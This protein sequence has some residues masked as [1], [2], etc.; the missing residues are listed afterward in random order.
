MAGHKHSQEGIGPY[1]RCTSA[2]QGYTCSG[3]GAMNVAKADEEVR[4][5]ITACLLAMERADPILDAMTER[6][7]ALA[8]PFDLGVLLGHYQS[9]EAWNST[10]LPHR[11]E[12]LALTI[13]KVIIAP[14]H[15]RRIP[16]ADRVRV[17]LLGEGASTVDAIRC[18]RFRTDD[19]GRDTGGVST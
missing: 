17:V 16:A 2:I 12:L 3:R 14:A 15:G 5:Q 19:L 9:T 8:I 1:Y 6:C 4:Q 11:R 7:R 18:G 10:P 13:D